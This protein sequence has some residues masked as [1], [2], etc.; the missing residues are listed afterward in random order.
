MEPA[1]STWQHFFTKYI[2]Y[3][4]TKKNVFFY[5]GNNFLWLIFRGW[6]IRP[7]NN[8]NGNSNQHIS[9]QVGWYCHLYKQTS[10]FNLVGVWHCLFAQF[11][12]PNTNTF[13]L[14]LSRKA[15]FHKQVRS[16]LFHVKL[17]L[18]FTIIFN[19]KSLLNTYD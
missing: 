4:T 1:S 11:L 8:I 5:P 12:Y 19:L 18:V 3:L 15:V 14:F 13:C 9:K 6:S 2:N 10:W 17:S 16:C 7:V